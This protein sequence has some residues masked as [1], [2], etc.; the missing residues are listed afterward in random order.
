MNWLMDS[1]SSSAPEIE[2]ND[3][4]NAVKIIFFICKPNEKSSFSKVILNC[5]G[6][7]HNSGKELHHSHIFRIEKPY[8]MIIL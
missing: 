2:A 5:L 4:I 1:E 6:F 8:P 3:Q 7:L